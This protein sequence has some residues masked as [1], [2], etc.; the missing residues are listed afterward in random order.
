VLELVVLADFEDLL[1]SSGDA[2]VKLSS[3]L[4]EVGAI[5]EGSTLSRDARLVC[6][7]GGG[8]N[9]SDLERAMKSELACLTSVAVVVY[10]VVS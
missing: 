7:S 10:V 3:K 1:V 4:N 9:V 2:L 8:S 5:S 6:A